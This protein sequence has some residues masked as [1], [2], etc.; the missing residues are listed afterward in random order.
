MTTWTATTEV[1]RQLVRV[2]FCEIRIISAANLIHI[3]MSG[4][5]AASSRLIPTDGA[6]AHSR[7]GRSTRRAA[8]V[9]LPPGATSR[10][11]R[12]CRRSRPAP[13]S[14]TAPRGKTGLPDECL[15]H[16]Q[17]LLHHLHHRLHQAAPPGASDTP[18]GNT[19]LPAT[20]LF[21][22]NTHRPILY[23]SW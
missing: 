13:G 9:C 18:R 15:L 8:E 14:T 1:S 23:S 20:S 12:C 16:L 4:V 2:R 22:H 11:P 5:A 10:S 19:G 7:P 17:H 21:K 3:T 6:V